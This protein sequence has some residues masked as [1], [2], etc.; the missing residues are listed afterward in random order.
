ME[1]EWV[2]IPMQRFKL[3]NRKR[4]YKI[5]LS[6]YWKYV[7]IAYVCLSAFRVA[8]AREPVA[9]EDYEQ[10]KKMNVQFQ[11][12][13]MHL[14]RR[15]NNSSGSLCVLLIFEMFAVGIEYLSMASKIFAPVHRT[16]R[17]RCVAVHVFRIA[18]P[19]N[20]WLVALCLLN[21][22]WF[23]GKLLSQPFNIPAK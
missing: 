18:D 20:R 15:Q 16:W 19:S 3:F 17:V 1:F 11:I 6:P 2:K 9:F 4:I 13:S 21:F 22:V 10:K 14:S 12:D 7:L 5:R 23:V 8:D